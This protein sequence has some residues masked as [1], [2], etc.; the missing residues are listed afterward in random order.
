MFP[1]DKK[2]ISQ[3]GL[4]AKSRKVKESSVSGLRRY[5][6]SLNKLGPVIHPHKLIIRVKLI[7]KSEKREKIKE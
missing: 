3:H 6:L 5:I 2:I 4:M 7:V 1:V